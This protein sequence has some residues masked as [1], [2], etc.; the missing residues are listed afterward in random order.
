VLSERMG[1]LSNNVVVV[2]I[3]LVDGF[4]DSRLSCTLSRVFVDGG[5]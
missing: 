3:S 2:L 4:G 5:N 1:E